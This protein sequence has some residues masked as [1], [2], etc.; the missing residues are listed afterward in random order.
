MNR[1]LESAAEVQKTFLPRH[2]PNF[3]GV[4]FGWSFTPCDELAGDML[5]ICKLDSRHV[6]IWVADVCGHGVAAALVS[7]TLS[8][9]LS[10]LNGPEN[11]LLRQAN[12]SVN[13]GRLPPQD[14]AN[15]LNGQ[16]AIDPETMRYFT[17]LYGILDV[18]TREFRYVSAGHPGPVLITH[19][20]E[21]RILP[22][23][24]PA[25]G[26]LP[27]PEFVEHR[28]TLS[29]GD[30]LYLY[31]D[32]ITESTN[33]EEEEFGRERMT[34]ILNVNRSMPLQ[35]SVDHLMEGLEEYSHGK[36][37]ADDLSLVAVEVV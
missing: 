3:P 34:E 22:M 19:D 10:T 13:G 29:P 21:S 26:I 28:V 7:V 1:N 32:G 16:F 5:D 4:S 2:P 36:H 27:K 37:P 14:I 35:Q 18:E 23:S 33:A 9:L 30:R 11:S 31:T 20:G 15:F 24:P 8:R 17:F 12:G 6:G 25:I